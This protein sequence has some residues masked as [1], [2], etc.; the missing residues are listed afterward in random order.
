MK[1]CNMNKCPEV[2]ASG[3]VGNYTCSLGC[4]K[5][6]K[7]NKMTFDFTETTDDEPKNHA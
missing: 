4:T 1:D 5:I 6:F 3:F 2:T 7:C